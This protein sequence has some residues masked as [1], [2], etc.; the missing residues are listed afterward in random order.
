MAK[1]QK[2]P[3]QL[4]K[5]LEKRL[6]QE[7]ERWNDLYENGGSDPFWSDGS[8]L[9]LVRNH[10]LACKGDIESLC[11]E[12]GLGFP[13]ICR[14]ETPEPVDMDYMARKDEIR[15][16]AENTLSVLLEDESYRYLKS[17]EDMVKGFTKRNGMGREIRDLVEHY[18]G[19]LDEL[20]RYL[21]EGDYV[22]MRR[23][24]RCGNEVEWFAEAARK[25]RDMLGN[26]DEDEKPEEPPMR[27][28]TL[29]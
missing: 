1:K 24:E 6:E 16:G 7:F 8:G 22:G 21:N 25:V 28:L 23:Y 12:Y 15:A 20:E 19:K 2:T 5:E 18:I 3:Q 10:I 17:L 9:F 4:L 13:D 26:L 14:R 11:N 29:F 27:Q